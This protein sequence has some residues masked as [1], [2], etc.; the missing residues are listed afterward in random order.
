MSKVE[1]HG[2]AI[3]SDDDRIADASGH[4]PEALRNDA[5]W[6]YFQAGLDS[7]ALTVLGR[8]GHEAN[9]SPRGRLRMILSSSSPGLERRPDGWWWNPEKLPWD[10]AIRTMLPNGGRVAVPGGRRVF[11]LFLGIGYDTFHLSRAE[12]VRVP[13]GVA[14]FSACDQ[15]RGAEALLA[16]RGL[17]PGSRLILDPAVPVSLVIWRK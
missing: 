4:T 10:Q 15:G 1:V 16:E 2:Y 13:G 7:S 9:P 11:D 8:L 5:D 14:L 12:G 17:R 3:I 6:A